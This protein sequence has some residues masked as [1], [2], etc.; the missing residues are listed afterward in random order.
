MKRLLLALAV[1]ALLAI[2]SASALASQSKPW[3]PTTYQSSKTLTV[4][5]KT[6]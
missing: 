2:L 5:T 1:A 4:T 6:R 3:D